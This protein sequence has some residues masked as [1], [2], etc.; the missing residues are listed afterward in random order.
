MQISY[1][2]RQ[3][4]HRVVNTRMFVRECFDIHKEYPQIVS[5][6]FPNASRQ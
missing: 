4:T 3:S 5:S 6:D 1:L 2:I